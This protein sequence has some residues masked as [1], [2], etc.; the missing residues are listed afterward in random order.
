MRLRGECT[1]TKRSFRFLFF[2]TWTKSERQCPSSFECG[3]QQLY[4]MSSLISQI[5]KWGEH[6]PITSLVIGDCCN[7]VVK[8]DEYGTIGLNKLAY[9]GLKNYSW[10]IHNLR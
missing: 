7:Q 5:K 10:I 8:N 1:L 2:W 4:H 3:N 6:K 9:T